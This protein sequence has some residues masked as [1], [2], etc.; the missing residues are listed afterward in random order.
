MMRLTSLIGSVLVSVQLSMLFGRRQVQTML[1]RQMKAE[2]GGGKEGKGSELSLKATQEFDDQLC[3]GCTE[4][5]LQD[6]IRET[7]EVQTTIE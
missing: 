1:L 2:K 6:H 3:N 4:S 7:M 5:A